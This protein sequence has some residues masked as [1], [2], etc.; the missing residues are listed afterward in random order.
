[1]KGKVALNSS[2]GWE[3]YL[4]KDFEIPEGFR[5]G[6]LIGYT[7]PAHTMLHSIYVWEYDDKNCFVDF[8]LGSIDHVAVDADMVIYV[9]LIPIERAY[10]CSC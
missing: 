10:E 6:G 2:T 1:M 8:N 4:H 5:I 3:S 9:N 7:I